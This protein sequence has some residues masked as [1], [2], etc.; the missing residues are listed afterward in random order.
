MTKVLQ[1]IIDQKQVELRAL[2]ERKGELGN[3]KR[4]GAARGKSKA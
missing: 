2:R 1:T 4:V 3:A